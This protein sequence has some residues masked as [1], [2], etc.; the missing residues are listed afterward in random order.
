MT[1]SLLLLPA[2]SLGLAAAEARAL[3]VSLEPG[4]NRWRVTWATP[5]G[6]VV[7]ATAAITGELWSKAAPLA[8]ATPASPSG[9]TNLPVGGL[10]SAPHPRGRVAVRTGRRVIGIRPEF[11]GAGLIV[12]RSQAEGWVDLAFSDDPPDTEVLAAALGISGDNLLA[13]YLVKGPSGE[14]NCRVLPCSLPGERAE[15]TAW[16]QLPDY[17][18]KPG[19]A[20]VMAGVHHGV[21]IAAGGAN[22]PDQPPW[23]NGVKR[24][25]DE[26]FALLPNDSTWRSAGRL[27]TPR[28]YAAV[29]TVPNGVMAFGGEN[30][31][32]VFND[33]LLFQWDGKQVVVTAAPALPVAVASPVAA[34][35]AGKVYLAGGYEPGPPRISGKGFFCLDLENLSAGWQ[36]LPTWPGPARALGVIAALDGA[37]YL[38]S[39]LELKIG[40]DGQPQTVYLN[41][42]YRYR[43]SSGWEKLPDLPW[44]VLAA[45]S[46]APVT[47]T[48]ARVFI[49]GGV[50]GR[51]VGKAPREKRVPEDIIYFDVARHEWCL[52]PERWPESVVCAPPVPM[53]GAWAFV[54]GETKAG[55]R[56]TAVPVWRPN[57]L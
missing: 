55:N 12:S 37:I 43:P 17:P 18:L 52:W 28:A 8:V 21:L 7:A 15:S 49:F 5:A 41:D 50:D 44:S 16:Q 38:I 10:A 25:Y 33:A 27:A 48:P 24:T 11:P 2:R 35:L 4:G 6:Q 30:A 40:A 46:P 9:E 51:Q 47:T 42:A 31:T 29:V 36:R 45:P 13:A 3:T 14:I 34:V 23:E 20:A 56:T 54:S 1:P 53:N 19:V 39:G 22:F 57:L 32:G 26:I